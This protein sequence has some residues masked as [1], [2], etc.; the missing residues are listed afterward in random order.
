MSQCFRGFEQLVKIKRNDVI[1]VLQNVTHLEIAIS[2]ELNLKLHIKRHI[3]NSG[4][5]LL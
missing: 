4:S 5:V 3:K 2:D 1:D